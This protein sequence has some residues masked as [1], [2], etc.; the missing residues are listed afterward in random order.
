[1]RIGIFGGS[2][3]P[4]HSEHISLCQYILDTMKL[5]KLIVIPNAIPPHKNTC[6]LVK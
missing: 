1:M 2:F 3:N 5:D 4:V 6:S